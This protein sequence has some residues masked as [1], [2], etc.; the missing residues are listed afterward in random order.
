MSQSLG[1][2]IVRDA[3]TARNAWCAQMTRDDK[4]YVGCGKAL[5]YFHQTRDLTRSAHSN[6][7]TRDLCLRASVKQSQVNLRLGYVNL[8]TLDSHETYEMHQ[9]SVFLSS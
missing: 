7:M 2:F 6:P 1:L 8:S 9:I 5:H 3:Q 4:P